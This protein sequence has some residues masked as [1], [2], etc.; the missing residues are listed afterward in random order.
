MIFLG[1]KNSIVPIYYIFEYG[2]AIFG[3]WVYLLKS[4]VVSI[5]EDTDGNYNS[6]YGVIYT[7]GFCCVPS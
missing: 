1:P 3:Y 7:R 6:Y 5:P 4:P 2:S